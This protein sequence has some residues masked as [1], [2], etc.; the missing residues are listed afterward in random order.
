MR[1]VELAVGVRGGPREQPDLLFAGVEYLHSACQ[2]GAK[3]GRMTEVLGR[4][5]LTLGA[6]F[7]GSL[8]DHPIV[9][10]FTIR[11]AVRHI[12]SQ[13]VRRLRQRFNPR[14]TAIATHCLTRACPGATSGKPASS[15]C[16]ARKQPNPTSPI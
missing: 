7:P 15:P 10:V 2:S 14:S 16:H 8:T 6:H 12:N 3:I 13:A 1:R 5:W 4:M 11:W 9:A